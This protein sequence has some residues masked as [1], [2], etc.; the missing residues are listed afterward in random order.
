VT[1][2]TTIEQGERDRA[3]LSDRVAKKKQKL[4]TTRVWPCVCVC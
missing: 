1:T 4:Q 2:T 3:A